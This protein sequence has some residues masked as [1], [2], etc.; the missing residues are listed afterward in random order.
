MI[1]NTLKT[2]ALVLLG[3]LI[4]FSSCR[5]EEMELINTPDDNILGSN[6]SIASLMQRVA[7]N[8]GS[9]DN[10]LDRANCFTIKYPVTVTANSENITVTNALELDNVEAVFDRYD[11]DPD[12]LTIQFPITII[13][14]DFEEIEV[15]SNS[16]LTTIASNCAGENVADTDIEC[17]DFQYPISA[18]IFNT[19]SELIGTETLTNDKELFSFI[20]AIDTNDIIN[21]D[22]PITTKLYNDTETVVNS[23]SELE[24][25]I[26]ANIS[27]CN[28]D[29]DYDYN[30]DDCNDCTVEQL[31]QLLT[32]CPAWTVE[33]LERDSNNTEDIYV[34]YRF[35]F[36]ADG[37]VMAEYGIWNYYGT[38]SANGSG[39]DI[40]VE[41][42][43]PELPD[44]NNSWR[45]HEITESNGDME[46]DL[47]LANEKLRYI[48][49]CDFESIDDTA[50]VNSITSGVWFVS[51]YFDDTDLTNT[52]NGY[53][54]NFSTNNNWI[55]ATGSSENTGGYWLTLA[56]DETD[57]EL[58]LN[59]L[60]DVL[61]LDNMVEDWD[62]VSVTSD[63][64]VLRDMSSGDGTIDELILE[65][66]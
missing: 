31:T 55:L 17:L 25:I 20:E 34:A 61:P 56:G 3:T 15:T 36:F 35:E 52:F 66:N 47:N 45:L 21:I 19:N 10:I 54:F 33:N 40:T 60:A 42:D 1:K 65:K 57:I 48:S 26:S 28:E 30:D 11:D 38:W 9:V 50:L 2:T 13:K 58:N 12:A 59:F 39:N 22:F 37:T 24:T 7:I 51:Y 53:T 18:S 4:L 5:K 32:S 43:V 16:E 14:D 6:S 8:D 62:V 27:A 46:C 63:M 29:D 64:I 49:N 44:C 41:I 23:L